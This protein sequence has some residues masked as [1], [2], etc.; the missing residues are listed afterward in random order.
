MSTL[1]L[2]CT[3]NL[4]RSPYAAAILRA[5]TA[6]MTTGQ[7]GT[8]EVLSR[9]AFAGAHPRSIPA[10]GLKAAELRG[11]DLTSHRTASCT[12]DELR[13]A[14]FV[15]PM[16]EDS[17][18]FVAEEI[19]DAEKSKIRRFVSFIDDLALREI[20]DPFLQ[21]IPFDEMLA[22]VERGSQAIAA[23]LPGA[24]RSTR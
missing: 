12:L 19:G 24:L 18:W 17:Y 6:N 2:V 7:D 14:R 23:W 20:A 3:N 16:D 11:V 1:I 13:Q 22:L 15:I 21:Q 10:A 9:G 5:A 4:I 8:V